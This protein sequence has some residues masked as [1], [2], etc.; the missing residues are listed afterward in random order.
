M[1]THYK[2]ASLPG[3]TFLID[4]IGPVY[5]R[6]PQEQLPPLRH[7][8]RLGAVMLPSPEI[9]ERYRGCLVA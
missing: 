6:R 5:A 7:T 4:G 3:R 1:Q 2:R 8:M 9:R